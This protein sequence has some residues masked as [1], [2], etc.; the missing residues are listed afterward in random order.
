MN[1]QPIH[2]AEVQKFEALAADWWDPNGPFRPLHA[3]NPPRMRFIEQ[4]GPLSGLK[5]A[6]IGCGGGL[7]A[8]A[9]ARAG[10]R[11]T[12]IDL[13]PGAIATASA[14]A[15]AA[16][17]EIDYR[18]QSAADLAAA[19]SGRYAR[20]TALELLEHLD[21]PP[22]LIAAGAELLAPGGV[23]VLATLNRTWLARV[24]AVW[25]AEYVLRLLPAG[26]HDADRFLKPSE[27][28]RWCRAVG[29]QPCAISGVGYNP[30]SGHAWLQLSVAVNYLLAARKPGL[31]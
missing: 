11:V 23:L 18:V 17:L 10:A 16:R 24:G 15:L 13:S 1:R 27:L 2:T 9:M 19:E 8:E 30:V 5:V 22:G 3:L 28:G 14:H 12:A 7:L 20:V 25:L 29:L 31:A 21:D 26:T 4:L 6:D